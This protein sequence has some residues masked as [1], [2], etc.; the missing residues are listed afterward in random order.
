[1]RTRV[2]WRGIETN[3]PLSNTVPLHAGNE[4]NFHARHFR[5]GIA[6]G[7]YPGHSTV[8][9]DVYTLQNIAMRPQFQLHIAPGLKQGY[10]YVM[11]EGGVDYGLI[12]PSVPL[13]G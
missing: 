12:D 11:H 13:G 6:G 7:G 2:P 8:Y 3:A 4:A 1:M 5:M 9:T 10:P